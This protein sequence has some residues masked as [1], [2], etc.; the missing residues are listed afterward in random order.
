MSND[1]MVVNIAM[2]GVSQNLYV[3]NMKYQTL[4]V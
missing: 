3:N 1:D 4:N 2:L